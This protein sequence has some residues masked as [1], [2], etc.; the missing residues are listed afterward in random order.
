MAFFRGTA[1]AVAEFSSEVRMNCSVESIYR[2]KG[3]D[4][5]NGSMNNW[6]DYRPRWVE[7]EDQL[8]KPCQH[9]NRM[10][11]TFYESQQG[12]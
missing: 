12:S 10:G 6:M 3:Q 9:G 2:G 11:I 4:C 1:S 7:Q 8:N 5:T